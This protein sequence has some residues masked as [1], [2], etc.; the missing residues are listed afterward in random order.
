[1]SL[2]EYEILEVEGRKY[3]VRRKVEQ[4]VSQS[5]EPQQPTL[6]FDDEPACQISIPLDLAGQAVECFEKAQ[7]TNRT[8]DCHV[9]LSIPSSLHPQIIGKS[10]QNVQPIKEECQCRISFGS[11]ED[12]DLVRVEGTDEKL[13]KEALKRLE[14]ITI[15]A[16]DIVR[17]THFI[18]LPF[19]S[20]DLLK[21]IENFQ[22]VLVKTENL[23]PTYL[24]RPEALHLTLQTLD[25]ATED[26]LNVAKKLLDS[27]SDRI[28]EILKSQPLIFDFS[29]IGIF[30]TSKNARVM[31]V[32]AKPN[33][34]EAMDLIVEEIK[35]VFGKLYK[36]PEELNI[37]LT[38]YNTNKLKDGQQITFN[39]EEILNKYSG[40]G[41]G[42]YRAETIELASMTNKM[43][44]TKFQLFNSIPL[45]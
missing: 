5:V 24:Q 14:A 27:M 6:T 31:F 7:F 28:Y 40:K 36:F 18:Y 39:A 4:H 42:K 10:G 44:K 9:Y 3:R 23:N 15:Q 13:V 1:M 20:H 37:H 32:K 34:P 43:F 22:E 29:G 25:I 2:D 41:F 8:T 26:Q 19:K 38:I 30:G 11:E 12:N 45:P 17:K 35:K 33:N 16:F 21:Q